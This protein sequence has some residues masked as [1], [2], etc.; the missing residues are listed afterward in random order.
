MAHGQLD[1]TRAGQ[2]PGYDF[3]LDHTAVSL[4]DAKRSAAAAG[5]LLAAPLW[6][7]GSDVRQLSATGA[8]PN[9]ERG[10]EGLQHVKAG[11]QVADRDLVLWATMGFATRRAPSV[12]GSCDDV[13][14]HGLSLFHR[15]SSTT[16]RPWRWT[17]SRGNCSAGANEVIE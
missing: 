12:G 2:H 17:P 6:V 13:D 14:S 1:L 5:G 7:S 10:G 8:Y 15:A 9:Q 3:T 4:L 11:R 16:T